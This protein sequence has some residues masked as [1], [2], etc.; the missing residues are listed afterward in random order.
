VL[1]GLIGAVLELSAKRRIGSGER[2]GDAELDLRLGRAREGEASAEREAERN[3]FLHDVPLLFR[4]DSPNSG[5]FGFGQDSSASSA[6]SHPVFG[7]VPG[8][9][10]GRRAHDN[11]PVRSLR[12]RYWVAIWPARVT[13]NPRNP[14]ARQTTTSTR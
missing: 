9:A 14:N 10:A 2:T 4:D 13:R 5:R 1:D 3:Q 8:C 12:K 11:S 7:A 6:K